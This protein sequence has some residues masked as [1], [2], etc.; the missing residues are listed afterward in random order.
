M[1]AAHIL[2]QAAAVSPAGGAVAGLVCSSS[3]YKTKGLT[4]VAV[5][6]TIIVAAVAVSTALGTLAAAIGVPCTP[7]IS[8]RTR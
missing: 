1:V 4:L 6:S 2:L 3:T 8:V 5:E 7:V